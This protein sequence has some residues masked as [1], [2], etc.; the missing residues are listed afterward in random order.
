[1]SHYY[2]YAVIAREEDGKIVRPLYHGPDL[3]TAKIVAD[4]FHEKSGKQVVVKHLGY[5]VSY[6][7][8]ALPPD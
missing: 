8:A 5:G 6:Y 2:A 1:M 7:R 4:D 3:R